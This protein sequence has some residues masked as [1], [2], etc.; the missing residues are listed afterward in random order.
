MAT[1][2]DSF[3]Q[4]IYEICS[5]M[6]DGAGGGLPA[7]TVRD[8]R[9]N[10]RDLMA[11]QVARDAPARPRPLD[12]LPGQ[13]IANLLL[14]IAFGSAAIPAGGQASFVIMPAPRGTPVL[15]ANTN[16]TAR[17][18]SERALIDLVL[19][20]AALALDRL[21]QLSITHRAIRGNNVFQA[22]ETEV[23]T[24]GDAWAAPPG[25]LQPAV[26][27]PPYSA[28]CHPAGR[29]EGEIAD[30][31]YA[32]GVLLISLALGAVP[33][34]DLDPAEV[35]RRKL[36]R[37]SFAALVG[38][39]RLPPGIADLT[40]GMLAED[41][42]HRPPPLLL[43][44]PLAARSR[45]TTIRPRQRAQQPIELDGIHAWDSRMLAFAIFRAPAAGLRLLRGPEIDSWLRRSLGNS[46]LAAQI[47]D[48]LRAAQ[49]TSS[50]DTATTET[51]LL[52]RCIALLDP[53]APSFW[54]GVALFPDGLGPLAA[55]AGGKGGDGRL[56]EAITTYIAADGA[57]LW[58]ETMSGR[59][60]LALQQLDSRQ[61][62]LLLLLQGWAGGFPRLRYALN[63]LLP[64]GS[65]LLGEAC[66]VRL[67]ELLAALE[68][69]AASASSGFVID[70]EIAGFVAARLKGR[71]DAEFVTM[72]LPEDPDIDP[73]GNRGLAQLRVLARLAG[74]EPGLSALAACA[75]RSA[76]PAV[77]RWRSAAARVQ[78][79]AQL[80]QA[81]AR[82]S[83]VAMS[84][85]LDDR[86]S[87]RGDAYI[88]RLAEAEVTMLDDAL[89]RLDESQEARRR[90]A[91]V[92]AQEI[93][94]AIG[95]M[96]LVFVVV[97]GALHGP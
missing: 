20:P 36:E 2:E 9:L 1:P 40:R 14:P 92:S 47:D 34:A 27:E 58:M 18:W 49:N 61:N 26:F 22:Q 41:P 51:R 69:A 39:N 31:I 54:R 66:V 7:F 17:P 81:A 15:P 55:A 19:R 87:L 97:A 78:R 56:R 84:N 67:P 90:L 59:V 91:R 76:E 8:R 10:R 70:A 95:V 82:G 53:L 80:R 65:P 3:V 94:A 48:E 57:A 50:S 21:A 96:A 73:P 79:L 13:P 29:G 89:T 63:P 30:D 60:D 4:G 11:V 45:R 33:M 32:L 38:T 85:I 74:H 93:T 43:A 64:C 62:R 44:D 83:L 12:T 37:G 23:V 68:R 42:V 46:A 24:L 71:L 72:G 77:G 16:V 52:L 88:A 6:L 5:G 75:L 28:M 86:V 25:S 35:I